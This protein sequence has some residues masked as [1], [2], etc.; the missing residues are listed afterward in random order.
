MSFMTNLGL[1][2]ITMRALNIYLLFIMF[3]LCILLLSSLLGN[4]QNRW[5]LSEH[6]SCIVWIYILWN[7]PNYSIQIIL[8]S[9]LCG[10]LDLMMSC[11][12]FF[13][14]G[15]FAHKLVETKWESICY[16]SVACKDLWVLIYLIYQ[17]IHWIKLFDLVIN[18]ISVDGLFIL[19]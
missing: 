10:F 14:F 1:T 16:K 11:I 12:I 9:R 13:A 8:V 3:L 17:E 15:F 4:W 2:L 18:L 6:L 5:S 7:S 19:F